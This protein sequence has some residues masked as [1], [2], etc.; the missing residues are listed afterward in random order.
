MS[1]LLMWEGRVTYLMSPIGEYWNL[2]SNPSY[3]LP[4]ATL[5]LPLRF[6]FGS[7]QTYLHLYSPDPGHHRILLSL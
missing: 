6:A 1:R 5:L 4:T 2:E 7:Y 3:L